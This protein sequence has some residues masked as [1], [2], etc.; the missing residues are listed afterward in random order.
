MRLY[1]HRISHTLSAILLTLAMGWG[2]LQAPDANA[3]FCAGKGAWIRYLCERW[4]HWADA[5]MGYALGQVR[6]AAQEIVKYL[7]GFSMWLLH[8]NSR[9]ALAGLLVRAE[10]GFEDISSGKKLA[11]TLEPHWKMAASIRENIYLLHPETI[12]S[13]KQVTEEVA[14]YWATCRA[15]KTV[16]PEPCDIL[17]STGNKGRFD[18]VTTLVRLGILFAGRCTQENSKLAGKIMQVSPEKALE[19]CRVLKQRQSDKCRTAAPSTLGAQL[20][21]AIT[22]SAGEAACSDPQLSERESRDCLEDFYAYQA[23]I[24]ARSLESWEQMM[25]PDAMLRTAVYSALNLIDCLEQALQ[26]YDRITRSDADLF[27]LNNRP[28]YYPPPIN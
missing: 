20:C 5:E 4:I 18:C 27:M 25:D 12:P 14:L 19:F 23:Y 9:A 10:A 13:L 6:Q 24:G 28:W 7:P 1:N 2:T 15:I 11:S 17:G 3:G 26:H 8:V 21:L 22:S 16:R